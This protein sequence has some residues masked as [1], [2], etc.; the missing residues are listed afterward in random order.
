[1]ATLK[2]FQIAIS[3][4]GAFFAPVAI[5]AALSAGPFDTQLLP[6]IIV[7]EGKYE[8]GV[9]LLKTLS[10]TLI[11]MSG[12]LA[13]SSVLIYR[14]KV[15]KLIHPAWNVLLAC[16][17]G[18]ALISSFS[19]LRFLFDLSLQL[20]VMPIDFSLVETKLYFQGWA[21]LAQTSILSLSAML[22]H[23]FRDERS[24]YS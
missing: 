5:V 18:A 4:L 22:L 24:A 15:R 9:E 19:G 14:Q 11:T 21:L 1:M 8:L 20:I 13:V 6:S 3:A 17:M 7:D 10:T 16:A 12:G 2:A 23:Y